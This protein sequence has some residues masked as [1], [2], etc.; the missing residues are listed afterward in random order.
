MFDADR[1]A[2]LDRW[3]RFADQSQFEWTGYGAHGGYGQVFLGQSYQFLQAMT[4]VR[5]RAL[6]RI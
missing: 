5:I 2:G 1:Y 6:T 4:N 3:I